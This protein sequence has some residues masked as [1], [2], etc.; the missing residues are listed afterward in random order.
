MLLLH[1]IYTQTYSCGIHDSTT[2]RTLAFNGVPLLNFVR[3]TLWT[4]NL[5]RFLPMR[6][7]HIYDLLTIRAEIAID[8]PHH[9]HILSFRISCNSIAATLTFV[10]FIMCHNLFLDS[11]QMSLI[12]FYDIA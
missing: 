3:A 10:L 4:N 5:L 7:N 6:I 12:I 1:L 8:I 9:H 11:L 2:F